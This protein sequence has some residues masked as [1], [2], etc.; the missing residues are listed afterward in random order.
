MK[1]QIT[2]PL[3]PQQPVRPTAVCA[4]VHQCKRPGAFHQANPLAKLKSQLTAV[5]T[6]QRKLLTQTS[7]IG[8]PVRQARGSRKTVGRLNDGEQGIPA[9]RDQRPFPLGSGRIPRWASRPPASPAKSV[10][11][12]F[13]G[14]PS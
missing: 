7:Q 13:G 14:S 2:T 12:R 9:I 8:R 4:G 5:G 6:G 1:V 11:T 3:V 10:K